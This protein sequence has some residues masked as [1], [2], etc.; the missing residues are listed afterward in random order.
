M[1]GSLLY[2][3]ITSVAKGNPKHEAIKYFVETGTYKADSTIMASQHYTHVYTT[4]IVPAL[5]EGS[6]NRAKNEGIENITFALG[7]S[8]KLLED[9]MPKVKDGAVFFIDAHQSGGDT[10]N[11]GKNVPLFEELGVILR[12]NVGPSMFIIDDV[13]FWKGKEKSAWD[14]DH[15]SEDLILDLFLE[16]NYKLIAFF[17][18][19]DR[20]LGINEIIFVHSSRSFVPSILKKGI[21]S[22][23][24]VNISSLPSPIAQK[25]H[26]L[27][28]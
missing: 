28:R 1:G 3:E 7:D 16:Y 2:E 26:P 8:V 4:E 25:F 14:W 15:V 10:S 24:L 5:Y 9:I 11:N 27:K 18:K 6:K 17:V 22:N 12:A 13:R 21:R 20:F 19:N 23:I